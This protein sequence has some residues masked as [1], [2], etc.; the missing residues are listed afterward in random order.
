MGKYS[1]EIYGRAEKKFPTIQQQI[2]WLSSFAEKKG[3]TYERDAV[4]VAE[5]LQ[6]GIEIEEEVRQIRSFKRLGTLS[7]EAETLK[8]NRDEPLGTINER[9]RELE[10]EA[11]E[12]ASVIKTSRS[13]SE[14]EKATE[15]LRELNPR[16]LGGIRSGQ[17]R[18][19]GSQKEQ[20]LIG[21]SLGIILEGTE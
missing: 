18:F 13:F 12:L 15:D 5:D 10:G 20:R 2:G 8:F 7:S 16:K 3:N 1:E 4:N 17:V 19:R 21:E 14:I 9:I 6:R 11:D